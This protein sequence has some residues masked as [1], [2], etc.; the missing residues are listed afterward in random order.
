MNVLVFIEQRDGRIHSAS[1]QLLTLAEQLAG[2]TGGRVE[3]VVTGQN[4]GDLNDAISRGGARKIYVVD[5]AEL[6]KYRVLPYCTAVCAA[7][8]ASK[9]KV[10]LF[11]TTFMG[12]DLASRV[13]ART[14]AALAIDCTEVSLDGD[15]I[16]VSKP[17]YA[18]KFSGKFK[19]APDR[20]QIVTV[21][22]NAYGA[23]PP[24]A[25]EGVEVQAVSL[26]L[27]DSDKRIAV[28]EI[29]ATGSGVKDVTEAD[30][31]VSGGR[32]LKTAE[33]FKII[34]ALAEVLDGAVG[35]SRAACDAGYQPHTRQVGLTGKVITPKLY[36]A[37]GIDGAIQHLAGMRGSKV[38]VAINTKKDAPIFKVATYGCVCDL[39]T[40]V[41]L[42]TEELKKMRAH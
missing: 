3:A 32:A 1:F 24:R 23:A 15:G 38:I 10:V 4:L 26:P 13:A 18:G 6:A 2:K 22:T 27:R 29:A 21:R 37:C 16:T 12:R 28:K 20:L 17:M 35:A 36:I 42:L 14:R 30:I 25:N 41:P 7:I 31:V 33:N 34:Y 9:P 40:L 11:P 39:F 19:L 5:D 8:E